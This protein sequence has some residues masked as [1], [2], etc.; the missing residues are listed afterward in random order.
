M[1]EMKINRNS[2]IPLYYQVYEILKKRIKSGEFRPGNYLPSEN[3][4]AE[5]YG[6]SR[7]TIR[8][9]LS[10]L[11]K[12]GLIEKKKGKGSIVTGP[13]NVEN[14]TGLHGFTEE[15]RIAGSKP[16]SLVLE[17]RL[18]DVPPHISEK[19]GL[20]TGSKVVLLK[21][22]RLL[23][24]IP[25]AIESAYINLMIDIRI[26][27]ILDMD[28]SKNSLYE[29]FR[30]TLKLKL[31]Y[32]DETLEVTK[33]TPETQKLLKIPKDACVVLRNRFTYIEDN[34]CI[35]YVQSLYRADRY[36]F[37]VR[38]YEKKTN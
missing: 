26:L 5:Y 20:P 22:L 33:A 9:A 24:D 23:D 12:E 37:S 4:L 2:P 25:Y 31:A 17:N 3:R 30:K 11:A 36:R 1:D 27:N 10:E 8:E 7:L 16:A 28:M 13:K 32:A 38:L 34:R 15:A 14:L 29:F 35:E 21:R 18:V 19:L 6:V